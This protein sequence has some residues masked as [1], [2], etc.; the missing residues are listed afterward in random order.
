LGISC[1]ALR[2]KSV[3]EEHAPGTRPK[4]WTQILVENDKVRRFA[5]PLQGDMQN[6]SFA[7][8][9]AEPAVK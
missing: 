3:T 2:E 1:S 5:T 6:I 9:A 7:G 4:A 8:P